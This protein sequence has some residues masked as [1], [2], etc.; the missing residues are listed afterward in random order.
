[1]ARSG[2][3]RIVGL[4]P[5]K[6]GILRG[7]RGFTYIEKTAIKNRAFTANHEFVKV[8][9]LDDPAV[10]PDWLPRPNIWIGYA[11]LGLDA[12]A[13]A[14][15]ARLQELGSTPHEETALERAGRM[16][17]ERRAAAGRDAS[18]PKS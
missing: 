12:T 16:I 17:R 15:D 14:L 7:E 10:A 6:A 18:T 1:V 5:T 8:I 2:A 11:S 4:S 9:P 3:A 13:T